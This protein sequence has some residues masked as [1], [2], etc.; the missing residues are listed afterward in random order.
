MRRFCWRG[1]L[2]LLLAA[3]PGP[4]RQTMASIFEIPLSCPEEWS[5]GQRWEM[6]FD[7]G[8]SFVEIQR[9]AVDWSGE[10]TGALCTWRDDPGATPWSVGASFEA[11]L[12]RPS[13]DDR[14]IG[15]TAVHGGLSTYPAPES[16]NL[17][18]AFSG[19]PWSDLLSGR[20][21]IEVEFVW[22][23][24]FS[25]VPV[26]VPSGHLRHATLIVEGTPVPEPATLLL[27]A[28]G[29]LALLAR[30]RGR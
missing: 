4:P 12:L 13:G 22:T 25:W 2:I 18:S 21:A 15:S 20:G 19:Q 10:I 6:E 26:T 7:L 27:V 11:D 5:P 28:L 17:E 9:V 3:V 29:A 24:P 23:L 1:V 8:V 30:R 16:F 14:R